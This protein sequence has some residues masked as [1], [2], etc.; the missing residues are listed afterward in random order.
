VIRAECRTN[1]QQD[2]ILDYDIK[3][4]GVNVLLIRISGRVRPIHQAGVPNG[5]ITQ[6]RAPGRD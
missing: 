2:K 6:E 4:I 1:S 3:D 5:V